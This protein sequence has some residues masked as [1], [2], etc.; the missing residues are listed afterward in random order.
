MTPIV[1]A[2]AL[3]S[4]LIMLVHLSGSHPLEA[5]L[6]AV[7][8][9]AFSPS[10]ESVTRTPLAGSLDELACATCVVVAVVHKLRVGKGL[11]R[12]P[13]WKPFALFVLFGLTG[14][15]LR[16]VP[17][18]TTLPS[19]LLVIKGVLVAWSIAQLPVTTKDLHRIAKAMVVV[20]S[21]ITL[22]SLL[23]LAFPKAWTQALG[24]SF[25]TRLGRTSLVGPFIHPLALGNVAGS[26]C[27]MAVAYVIIARGS[28][29]MLTVSL[30]MFMTTVS[31]FRRTAVAGAVVGIMYVAQRTRRSAAVIFTI[32]GAG[33]AGLVFEAQIRAVVSSTWTTYVATAT[34]ARTVLTHF[35]FV[36][37]D[38]YAP[39]GAGFG[40]YGSY[41]AGHDYSPLYTEFGF[42]RIWG[43]NAATGNA[44]FLYDT[45][46]PAILGESGY[47]GCAFFVLFLI[48]LWRYMTP[49][50]RSDDLMVCWWIVGARGVF[51]ALLLASSAMPVFYSAPFNS[52]LFGV[53]GV[54]FGI[55]NTTDSLNGSSV[56]QHRTSAG[57]RGSL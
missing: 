22:C 38:R 52:V 48:S 36:V 42:D 12:I 34:Q 27:I 16:G 51:V 56:S 3:V 46:W 49:S 1:I 19:L 24:A 4:V 25:S 37:A 33:A 17:L 8:A 6:C 40:R 14:S 23:N 32:L 20:A 47:L 15:A 50:S 54:A 43:L 44:D 9:G 26:L 2:V 29:S 41:Y 5:A 10:L 28:G 39:F 53:L 45:Q 57:S 21:F 11:S 18:T 13:G 31:S 30:A 7:T 35:A 55:R